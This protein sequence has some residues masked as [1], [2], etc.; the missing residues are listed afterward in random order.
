MKIKEKLFWERFR[1][2]TLTPEKGK[3]PIILLPRIRKILE[4]GIQLN[5]MFI[6]SGGAGKCVRKNTLIKI[7]NKTTG[8]IEEITFEEFWNRIITEK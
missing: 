5:M 6:G 1:P 7:K 4:K 3:I 8:V 2:N